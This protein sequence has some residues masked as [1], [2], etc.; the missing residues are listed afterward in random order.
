HRFDTLH[1]RLSLRTRRQLLRDRAHARDHLHEI[2]DRT[3]ALHLLQRRVKI[4]ERESRLE[5]L[6][7]LLLSRLAIDGLL[8]LLDEREHIAH[9]EDALRE[10]I[11]MED[12]ECVELLADAEELHRDARRRADGEARAAARVAIDLR[13]HETADR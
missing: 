7:R 4:L 9:P 12:L 1:L 11:G 10:P 5:E 6:L 2:A 13:Q 8:R 3:H